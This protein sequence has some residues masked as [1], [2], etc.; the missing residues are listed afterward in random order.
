M[1][2][3]R[4]MPP[5]AVVTLLLVA[6]LLALLAAAQ[7]SSPPDL[8]LRMA[9]ELADADLQHSGWSPDGDSLLDSLDRE[10][11]GNTLASLRSCSG[12]GVGFCRYRY[13]RGN[14]QLDVITVPNSD[15]DGLVHH[16]DVSVGEP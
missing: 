9:I 10:L 2:V 7:P 14:Q 16:W 12:T 6:P 5:D 1:Q 13:R 3:H 15:G 11:S 8:R 4:R